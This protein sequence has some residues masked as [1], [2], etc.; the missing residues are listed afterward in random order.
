MLN[1]T[2]LAC[3]RNA[4]AKGAPPVFSKSDYY[5]EIAKRAEAGRRAGE[6]FVQGF[7]RFITEEADGTVLYKTYKIAGGP[8]PQPEPRSASEARRSRGPGVREDLH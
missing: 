7:T 5:A 8:L 6:T 1:S 4:I 3:A 2:M